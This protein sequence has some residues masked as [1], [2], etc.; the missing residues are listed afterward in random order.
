MAISPSWRVVF[1]LPLLAAVG[2]VVWTTRIEET[3]RHHQRRSISPAALA[4]A[5]KAVVSNRQTVAFAL[6]VT[7]LFA[8]LTSYIGGSEIIV[9]E[10][11]GLHRLF[12]V[13]FGLLACTLGVGSLLGGRLVM[14]MGLHR[15]LRAAAIYLV[16]S[17]ALLALVAVA[18]H[19]KPPVWM[20]G[21]SLAAV[22]PAITV[23]IPNCNASAMAP[24]P[25]VAGM[26][27]ALLGT[28]ATGGGAV[29]GSVVDN[30]FDGTVR[31]FGI[32]VL[33]Y[34]AAASALILFGAKPGVATRVVGVVVVDAP[35]GVD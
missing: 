10:V 18:T 27:A 3:L 25:H 31:P 7:F 11:F 9:T 19:G 8:I 28:I 24:T 17:A 14:R 6:A 13:L 1:V 26:A 30:A 20:F 12:P 22:L 5:F 33:V 35:A 4:E 16:G 29:L 2:L 23:L 32:G 34:A 15:L 21:L